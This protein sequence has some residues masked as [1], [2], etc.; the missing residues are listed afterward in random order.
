MGLSLMRCA[1][2]LS[3]GH[4]GPCGVRVSKSSF[5]VNTILLHF[6]I[7]VFYVLLVNYVSLFHLKR[8]P[9]SLVVGVA[10]FAVVIRFVSFSTPF[11]LIIMSGVSGTDVL[12]SYCRL[13]GDD[14]SWY[15]RLWGRVKVLDALFLRYT[16]HNDFLRVPSVVYVVQFWLWV[17]LVE[18]LVFELST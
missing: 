5:V 14:F 6:C 8:A 17:R 15:R 11:F 7:M 3:L 2:R 13:V 12:E 4:V 10:F 9:L 18:P 16:A 1:C